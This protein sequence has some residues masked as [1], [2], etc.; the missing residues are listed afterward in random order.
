[1]TESGRSVVEVFTSPFA[2]LAGYF[3][4]EGRFAGN[5]QISGLEQFSGFFDELQA[6]GGYT[7]STYL[8]IRKYRK[9][10]K[11]AQSEQWED[12]DP[13]SYTTREEAERN[14][15]MTDEEIDA[16]VGLA[17]IDAIEDNRIGYVVDQVSRALSQATVSNV[18]RGSEHLISAYLNN[19]EVKTS[20]DSLAVRIYRDILAL[21]IVRSPGDSWVPGMRWC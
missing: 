7:L 15:P 20:Q 17:L 11:E 14:A 6:A 9:E 18:I 3:P 1:M 4:V 10:L 8:E 19:G 13:F 16:R 5:A 12:Y 21:P 2:G